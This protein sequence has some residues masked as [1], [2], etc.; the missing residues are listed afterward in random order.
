M[1]NFIL[2][3][4]YR[5]QTRTKLLFTRRYKKLVGFAARFN[6][7]EIRRRK[8]NKLGFVYCAFFICEKGTNFHFVLHKKD[9]HRL[10][11]SCNMHIIDGNIVVSI[12]ETNANPTRNMEGSFELADPKCLDN[13]INVFKNIFP[14]KNNL[15]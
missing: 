11:I 10:S 2:P 6:G 14:T 9:A 7:R 15:R 4:Y 1:N 3:L 12:Y 8:H 5:I 13:T